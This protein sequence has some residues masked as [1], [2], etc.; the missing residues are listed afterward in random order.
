MKNFINLVNFLSLILIGTSCSK[1]LDAKPDQ[2]LAV[3]SS[4]K[5]L[6]AMMDY[7]RIFNIG[8]SEIGDIASDFYYLDDSDW[9]TR[10]ELTRE[11]YT[12]HSNV[13]F[14]SWLGDYSRI[15]YCN[16]VLEKVK[17]ANLGGM[18]EEDR[19]YIAGTAHFFRGF[20]LFQLA[21]L[22]S[23]VYELGK[24][25]GKLGI[26]LRIEAD[27]NINTVRASLEETFDQIISDFKSAAYSLPVVSQFLT[28]PTRPTAYAALARTYLIMGDYKQ[29]SLYAD[30]CLAI[31]GDLIDYNDLDVKAK[32]PFDAENI[33]SLFYAE[34]N[35][36]TG[37]FNQARAKVNPD[38]YNLYKDNDL[39]K[40]LFFIENKDGS[41]SFKGSYAGRAPTNAFIGFAT[42]EVYLMRAEC[43]ARL[44]NVNR[45]LSDLNTL[46]VKRYVTGEFKSVYIQDEELLL[47]YILD[48]RKKELI[49]RGGIAWSDLRRLNL[50]SR[51]ARDL[52][53]NVQ[54]KEYRL[55]ANDLRYTFLIPDVVMQKT[56]IEQNIR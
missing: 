39:R 53:R 37:V 43:E 54:G 11:N 36:T 28:R 38:I 44:G 55:L 45:A 8:H 46:L 12:W 27:F 2:S 9:A 3:P 49:F 21:N 5:D 24:N 33:E 18:V 16:I 26:P 35:G 50:D 1:F 34:M 20:V 40:Q 14:N 7:E 23:P 42:D 25:E 56:V 51:F 47:R 13:Q 41:H 17:S 32:I 29:A 22:Y 19:G 10:N 15:N 31:R 6:R 52:K 48:E 4:L 30:S